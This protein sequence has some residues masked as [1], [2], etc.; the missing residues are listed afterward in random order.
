MKF[1]RNYD[2]AKFRPIAP[3]AQ[4]G[5]KSGFI[6]ILLLVSTGCIYLK[7]P[8]DILDKET[9]PSAET[10]YNTLIRQSEQVSSLQGT[11][12][13]RAQAVLKKVRLEA[14]IACD[15]TGR[16]RLEVMD[17]LDR[18]L[19]LVIYKEGRYEAY[20][21]VESEQIQELLGVPI[22][23]KELVDLA[24][25]N[26]F[27]ICLKDLEAPQLSVQSEKGSFFLKVEEPDTGVEHLIWFNDDHQ[28]PQRIRINRTSPGT[29]FS[30]KIQ[31]DFDDYQ[32]SGSL[33]FPYYIRVTDLERVDFFEINYRKLDFNAELPEALFTLAPSGNW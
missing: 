15:R 18:I 4:T 27:F 32:E 20:S 29:G 25:A 10:L 6:L 9:L 28:R 26:P 5:K 8:S 14:L 33:I 3:L 1:T 21:M 7:G 30:E 23:I 17:F 2:F 19:F 11:A 13:I 22:R 31:V 12:R 16:L 24:L